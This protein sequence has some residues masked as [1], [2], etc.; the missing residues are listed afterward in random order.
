MS[1]C[2][3]SNLAHKWSA[4]ESQTA[5]SVMF[6]VP[7]FFKFDTDLACDHGC[8]FEVN[9]VFTSTLIVH[10][11]IFSLCSFSYY[12]LRMRRL[13]STRYKQIRLEGYLIFER[14]KRKKQSMSKKNKG[15]ILDQV[16]RHSLFFIIQFTN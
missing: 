13:L 5:W 6:A 3:L 12:A 4:E 11:L 7:I 2:C 14:I 10:S 8:H 16:T 1:S 9:K 15:D